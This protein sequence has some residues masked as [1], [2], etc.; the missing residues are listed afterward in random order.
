MVRPGLSLY[1]VSPLGVQHEKLKP[2]MKMKA[3]VVIVKKMK[4][5][6]KKVD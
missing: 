6:K 2:V 3:S 5:G 4:I 1:G